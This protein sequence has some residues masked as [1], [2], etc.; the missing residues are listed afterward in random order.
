MVELLFQGCFYYIKC[1]YNLLM[2][3]TIYQLNPSHLSIGIKEQNP[4]FCTKSGYT[5][6]GFK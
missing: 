1:F 2:P 5:V 3:L 4:V 6:K